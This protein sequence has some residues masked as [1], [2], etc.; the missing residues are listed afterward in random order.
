[1]LQVT[2]LDLT[3]VVSFKETSVDFR[4]GLTYVRGVN[5]DSDLARPTGNG[6]G[7]SLFFSAIPNVFFSAPPLALKKK[8]RK[9]MLGRKGSSIGIIFKTGNNDNEYEI[10][11]RGSNYSIFENGQDLKIPTIPKAEAFIK[12]LFPISEID[13]YSRCYVST[14]RPYSLLRDSDSDRLQHIIDIARLDQYSAIQKYF[15][16]KA[17]SIK[18]N[19]IRLSVLEQQLSSV[20]KKLADAKSS[21]TAKEYKVFRSKYEQSQTEIEGL[22]AEKFKLLSKQQA[23]QSL[24]SV[25]TELDALRKRY[26]YKT[27]PTKQLKILKAEK[28]AAREW[29]S[30]YSDLLRVEKAQKRL[31]K[32]ISDLRANLPKTDIKWL[33]SALRG[34]REEFQKIEEFISEQR[35]LAEACSEIEDG[36]TQAKKSLS[37][38]TDKGLT[39]TEID[40]DK[41][42]DIIIA[43]AKLKLR[44]GDLLEHEDSHKSSGTCPTCQSEIDFDAIRTVVKGERKAL[45][46]AQLCKSGKELLLEIRRL[47]KKKKGISYDADALEAAEKKYRTLKSSIVEIEGHISVFEELVSLEKQMEEIE[48]PDEPEVEKPELSVSVIEE[49]IDLC[50]EIEKHLKAKSAFLENHSEF[51]AFRSAK[52]V[53]KAFQEI[54]SDLSNIDK[55]LRSA[56]SEQAKFSEAIAAYEQYENT[57]KIYKDEESRAIAEIAKVKPEVDGKKLVSILSKAYGTKGLRAYAANSFCSLLQNNLNHY[58]DLIFAEPFEFIVEASDT[59]V[60]ILVDRN[61]GKPDAVSDVRHLSGAESECFALLCAA[62]LITLTPDSRKLNMLV[63]DEPT[64]HFHAVTRELFNQKFLPF[65]RDLVPSVFVIT[66]HEDDV[67]PNSAEWVVEKYKGVSKLIQ[68]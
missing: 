45:R 52:A 63:L 18:D 61:N 51:E 30:Y 25:E 4:R 24:I 58:R 34:G 53:K 9:Y 38:L 16:V 3:N 40:L 28:L 31:K 54:E 22:K 42:Y 65:I 1:M 7:K 6:T 48:I 29:E 47:S 44:L 39:V 46:E 12:K 35:S 36:I 68:L 50:H 33:K 17:S 10:I 21:V 37:K 62:S 60:S 11:Q 5:K 26:T 66:P 2:G 14:Q 23:L 64:A 13:F 49:H 15:A 8:S 55:K 20:R 67:S 32:S 59:G 41:D 56:E 27:N 43:E 19:E 57:V